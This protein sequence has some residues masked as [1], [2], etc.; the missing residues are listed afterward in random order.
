VE[1]RFSKTVFFPHKTAGFYQLDLK[2]YQGTSQVGLGHTFSPIH[3][4]Q[5]EG[6]AFFPF[7][8]FEEIRLTSQM[9][10]VYTLGRKVR[11]TGTVS[12]PSVRQIDFQF[13]IQVSG[14]NFRG[15]VVFT[16]PVTDGEFSVDID[17][18]AEEGHRTGDGSL[19]VHL[20][21]RGN[22]S[23][24]PRR[25]RPISIVQTN[26]ADFDRDG[27]V[28]FVD[29]FAFADA[30]GTSSADADFDPRYDLD[31]DGTVGFGDFV[32]FSRAFGQ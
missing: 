27:T 29:F 11:V 26:T 17:F 30:F 19:D 9:P 24:G 16:S 32:I 8:F 25:F 2:R 1:N 23:L 14:Q 15:S 13:F 4:T 12:D 10:V 31:G 21:R 20:W 28:G 5:G 22:S 18:S 3:V 6:T 7:D